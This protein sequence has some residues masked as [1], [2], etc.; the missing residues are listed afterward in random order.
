MSQYAY[1]PG[2]SL[3]ASGRDYDASMR[4]VFAALGF[5]LREIPDWNC[6]GASSG[7]LVNERTALAWNGR[8]L[9]WPAKEKLDVVVP[10]TGCLKN[11]RKTITKVAESEKKRAHLIEDLGE[12]YPG[13][14]Q[15][16]HPMEVFVSDLG[17]DQVREKVVNKYKGIKVAPYYG[18]YMIRPPVDYDRGEDPQSL[19]DLIKTCG[20]EVA[21]FSYKTKCCGGGGFLTQENHSLELSADIVLHAKRAGAD[22]ILVACPLCDMLLDGYQK[23][24]QSTAGEK[25]GLPVLYFTQFLGLAMGLSADQ[26]GL[27]GRMVPVDDLVQKMAE[28]A[29]AEREAEEER[30]AK[31]AARLERLA[32][33]KA[34]KAAKEQGAPS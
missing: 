32:K 19:D 30:K 4:A 5:E 8:N 3:S 26:L 22:V 31:E 20:A 13:G 18:C 12:P 1:Y 23:R 7:F 15:A 33:A 24:L 25:L 16:V 17:W 11:M 28:A 27:D 29:K 34:E 9:L 10:C 6:C 14:I 2:C 21:D